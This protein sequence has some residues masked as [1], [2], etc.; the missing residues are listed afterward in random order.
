MDND[1]ATKKDLAEL[2]TELK[3]DMAELAATLRAEMHAGF[4]RL[5]EQMRDMQTEI[6]KGFLPY[7]E[8]QNVRMRNLEAN[9]V[10]NDL[11]LKMRMEVLERRLQQIE[12]KLLL[13][14]PPS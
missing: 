1:A 10:N 6:L 7:Q 11:A 3:Q 8:A 5:Q 14:P 12:K 9:T 13:N 2:R 4:D